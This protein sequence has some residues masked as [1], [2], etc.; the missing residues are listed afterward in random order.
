MAGIQRAEHCP[1]LPLAG[2]KE[3][4]LLDRT[5]CGSGVQKVLILCGR[6]W[7]P[8]ICRRAQTSF[9]PRRCLRIFGWCQLGT[10][11]CRVW[12]PEVG[13]APLQTRSFAL[14]STYGEGPVP[15]VQPT[16]KEA[17]LLGYQPACPVSCTSPC[18]GPGLG[19]V[20]L[21]CVYGGLLCSRPWA[22]HCLGSWRSRKLRKLSF[23][24][25]VTYYPD[26]IWG[27]LC[28]LVY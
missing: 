15:G 17:L 4:Q 19:S 14:Q 18:P 16:L 27:A 12:V 25:F 1:G 13:R 9:T 28:L 5:A 21:L 2:G 26:S 20:Y 3:Y 24:L 8:E 11:P 6:A 7:C 10:W 22:P 23:C